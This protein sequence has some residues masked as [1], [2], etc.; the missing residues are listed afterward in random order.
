MDQILAN[1]WRPQSFD[2]VVSQDATI[3]A[4]RN[5]LTG[6]V[7][8]QCYIF[9]GIHG[10]GKTT[11]ARIFAKALNCNTGVTFNPCNECQSCLGIQNSKDWDFYEIDA[12]SRTGIDQMLKLLEL[13]QSPPTY[14]RYKIFLIDEVHQ[15]STHSFNA[16]LKTLEQPPEYMKFLF[17]TTD[18]TQ[19][20]DTVR[21]R[22][23]EFQLNPMNLEKMKAH[24]EVICK[25]DNIV[26]EDDAS[27][28][29]CQNSKGSM[30]DAV[31][32]LQS[33]L[34]NAENNCIK[35]EHVRDILGIV[36]ESLFE[37]LLTSI[38]NNELED[39]KNN[40]NT[41]A[42]KVTN[43]QTIVDQLLDYLCKKVLG[44][45]SDQAKIHNYIQVL[46]AT[47]KDLSL[48]PSSRMAFEVMIMRM[49]AFKLQ[50]SDL[51]TGLKLDKN[52][53]NSFNDQSTETIN[54]KNANP[55]PVGKA[56]PVDNM[57]RI[58]EQVANIKKKQTSEVKKKDKIVTPSV[59]ADNWMGFVED[60]NLQGLSKEVLSLSQFQ[61]LDSNVLTIEVKKQYH[62]MMSAK[63]TKEIE[64]VLKS[65]AIEK[66]VINELSG[67][68][69]KTIRQL[70]IK[71]AMD[72]KLED[73]QRLEKHPNYK[74]IKNHIDVLIDA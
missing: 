6:N 60:L 73:K 8:H 32:L 7:L 20:P 64:S 46:I 21:S 49:F 69:E 40:L 23:I 3:S 34:V 48:Y 70:K 55:I 51:L 44:N 38:L 4:L 25:K 37:D 29:I 36:P 5:A 35:I 27:N 26:I 33:V 62:P 15:L 74:T 59:N 42:M 31:T 2:K 13:T 54:V 11:I 63:I 18:V 39:L 16:L 24:L 17:A 10:V 71:E 52:T 72:N 61:A 41:L 67:S 56:P 57:A 22:C 30:R 58:Q 47:K 12:A 66:L 9:S 1:I 45:S 65:Y 50:A 28:L 19:I 14:S 68:D 43:Y 53:N